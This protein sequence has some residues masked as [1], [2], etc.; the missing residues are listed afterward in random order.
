M[1]MEHKKWSW[2]APWAPKLCVGPLFWSP[3]PQLLDHLHML[4]W[5][6]TQPHIGCPPQLQ[7][8][9]NQLW[10]AV[11]R[12]SLQGFVLNPVTKSVAYLWPHVAFWLLWLL[13]NC[14]HV[15]KLSS[16][17]FFFASA[18]WEDKASGMW[19]SSV[20][21]SDGFLGHCLP[22]RTPFTAVIISTQASEALNF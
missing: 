16:F 7:W 2:L 11:N 4:T 22:P 13:P 6:S 9:E 17:C 8:S 20:P 3:P 5:L 12:Q 21:K 14:W 1:E 18:S 15:F 10:A 19:S